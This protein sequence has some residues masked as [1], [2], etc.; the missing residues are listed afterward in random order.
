MTERVRVDRVEIRLRGGSARS[1]RALAGALGAALAPVLEGRSGERLEHVEAAP[2]RVRRSAPPRQAAAAV[3]R[4]VADG[5]D[6]ESAGA[7]SLA[8]SLREHRGRGEL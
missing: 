7:D 8:S 3:A 2:V 6:G 4:A 5:L 1:A